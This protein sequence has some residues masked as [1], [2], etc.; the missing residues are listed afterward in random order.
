MQQRLQSQAG[1]AAQVGIM[2]GLPVVVLIIACAN[3]ANLML[4][5]ARARR[6]RSRSGS[7]WASA[8]CGCCANC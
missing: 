6:A 3:M 7:H 5:R 8:G 1:V 4:G 2:T